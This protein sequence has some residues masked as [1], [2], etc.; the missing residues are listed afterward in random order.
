MGTE[1]GTGGGSGI[2]RA[3]AVLEAAGVWEGPGASAGAV[4]LGV[5]VE[6]VALEEEA[7]WGRLR[8]GSWA[9][10]L[11][12]RCGCRGGRILGVGKGPGK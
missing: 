3:S 5:L 4:V 1:C 9:G 2:R 10:P 12:T 7:A 8:F 6:G 11:L